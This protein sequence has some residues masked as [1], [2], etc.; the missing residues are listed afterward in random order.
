MCAIVGLEQNLPSCP[1]GYFI[2]FLTTTVAQERILNMQTAVFT[3]DQVIMIGQPTPNGTGRPLPGW[4]TAMFAA[5]DAFDVD[6]F[7]SFLHPECMFRF[8][9]AQPIFGH[10]AIRT[11]VSGLFAA[12]QG[13]SHADLAA[14]VH[15]DATLCTG[16][17]TYTRYDDSTLTVPFAVVF[18]L[19]QKLVKEYLIFVDNS[20][21]FA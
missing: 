14:W 11:A 19:E 4:L 13:I 3:I 6:R 2:Y 12:L 16:Q 17:V 15:P 7:L 10:D 21:L 9:N 5:V 18:R 1:M 8:G 20:P